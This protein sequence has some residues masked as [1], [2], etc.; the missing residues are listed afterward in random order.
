[1]KSWLERWNEENARDPR[2]ASR[3]TLHGFA[4]KSFLYALVAL[5]PAMHV[6]DH[7]ASYVRTLGIICV[8]AAAACALAAIVLRQPFVGKAI[9]HWDEAIGYAGITLFLRAIASSLTG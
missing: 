5:P 7:L 9:N 3:R 6:P 1:M 2:L 8:A 4:Y